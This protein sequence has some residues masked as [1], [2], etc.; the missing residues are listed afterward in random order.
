MTPP[1][2]NGNADSKG[3]L[4]PA[5][6]TGGA[7]GATGGAATGAGTGAGPKTGGAG[8]AAGGAGSGTK[9]NVNKN[10]DTTRTGT[11]PKNTGASP[12]PAPAP[13]LLAA[14]Q[15]SAEGFLQI[16]PA[17][18]HQLLASAAASPPHHREP[19]VP[20]FWESEPA[21]WFQVFRG[22]YQPRK[23]ETLHSWPFSTHSYLW[24]PLLLSH[25][26]VRLLAASLRTSSIKL[27][28][29]CSNAL[30]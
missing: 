30:K 1:P 6:A 18:L 22:H 7:G 10:A 8:G 13:G 11:I 29:F 15:P 23:A 16:T 25:Y 12:N 27:I 5:G 17:M 14:P 26:A 24:F 9:S 21:A 19:P 28:V 20:K 4:P 2:P 3:T